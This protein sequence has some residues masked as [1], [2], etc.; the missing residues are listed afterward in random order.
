MK[1]RPSVLVVDDEPRMCKSIVKLLEVLDL[2]MM[3]ANTGVQAV[4]AMRAQPFDLFLLDIIMPEI[5]GFEL[6]ARAKKLQPDTPVIIITGETSVESAL[7][8]L[9]LGAYDYLKKPMEPAELIQ[10][11]KNALEKK[12]LHDENLAMSGK[13][14]Q[15]ERRYRLLVQN[16]P[17]MIYTLDQDGHFVF[18]ND[19]VEKLLGYDSSLLIGKPY[20]SIVLGNG[21]KQTMGYHFKDRVSELVRD[22]GSTCFV[23]TSVS[24]IRDSK[25]RSIGCRG[26]DRDI[27]RRKRLEEDLYLSFKKLENA[28]F[29]TIMGLAKLAEYRDEGTGMHLERIQEYVRVIA[30]TMAAQSKYANY[31]TEEYILDVSKSSILHDI[32]KVGIPDSI[33]LKPGRLLPEEFEIIKRHCVIGGDALKEMEAKIEGQSFL[34]LGKEAAYHHHEK[35]D[36]SGYPSGLKGEQI[37]LS[38][39][40]VALA[41]VYDALTSE[42]SY[43]KAFSHEHSREIIVNS[44]G[45][46]FDPDVVE[47]FLEQEDTFRS[48]RYHLEH[49]DQEMDVELPMPASARSTTKV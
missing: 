37:P 40:Q 14:I 30:E 34:T 43:K 24:I 38:A 25:G 31:I 35:W 39:R 47:A 17:D 48:I 28:K 36:G 7:K 46:H 49:P 20:S 16:S 10:N 32:G 29:L 9:K 8:A 15:S 1:R 6:M 26:I 42:R 3:T 23:E 12:R 33:L 11:V 41:D 27:S 18:I 21:R 45:T 2:N 5:D 22:D 19:T 44:K 4:Q 13:L